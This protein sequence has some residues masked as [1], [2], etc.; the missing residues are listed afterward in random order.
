MAGVLEALVR[1]MCSRGWEIPLAT[2]VTE[3]TGH[4]CEIVRGPVVRN[5][6]GLKV[7]DRLLPLASSITKKEAQ[8]LTGLFG[9]CTQCIPPA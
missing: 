5:N 6:D 9:F 4:F 1:H 3:G 7:K 8:S 2:S